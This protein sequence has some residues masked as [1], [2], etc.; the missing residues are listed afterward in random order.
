LQRSISRLGKSL[1]LATAGEFSEGADPS[2]LLKRARSKGSL[3]RQRESSNSKRDAGPGR[4]RMACSAAAVDRADSWHDE[5]ASA[6]GK[7]WRN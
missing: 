4:A 3:S 7:F 1:V 6:R 2:S 5:A